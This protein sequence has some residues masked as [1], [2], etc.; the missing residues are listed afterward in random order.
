VTELERACHWDVLCGNERKKRELSDP[1]VRDYIRYLKEEVAET[2]KADIDNDL[3]E[4]L[5]G[6]FDILKVTAGLVHALGYC[7]EE[8]MR[9]GNDSN[10]SKFALDE[11]EAETSA[12]AYNSKERYH[13]CYYQEVDGIYVIR[14]YEAGQSPDESVGKVLKNATTYHAPKLEEFMQLE[15]N[16]Q[17]TQ[18][19]ESE[20]LAIEQ[21][22]ST[23]NSVEM[24]LE[25]L[26]KL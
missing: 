20:P 18:T 8:L 6:C 26:L 9:V 21:K 1:L 4:V 3:V 5:D 22:D 2:L 23:E 7:P 12:I 15:Q 16:T 13:D 10:F 14:G 25:R 17:A 11:W 19:Q 24:S